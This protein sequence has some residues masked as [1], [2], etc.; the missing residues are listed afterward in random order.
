MMSFMELTAVNY[1][2]D[3]VGVLVGVVLGTLLICGKGCSQSRQWFLEGCLR[4]GDEW[5]H[6]ILLDNYFP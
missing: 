1:G 3:E 4:Y 6:N 5:Q 2:D